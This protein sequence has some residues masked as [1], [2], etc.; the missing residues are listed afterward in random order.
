MKRK[1]LLV[2]TGPAP[3]GALNENVLLS[4][5]PGMVTSNS[6]PSRSAER[7][8]LWNDVELQDRAQFGEATATATSHKERLGQQSWSQVRGLS[9]L[10]PYHCA[11]DAPSLVGD[12]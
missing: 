4:E 3:T 11:T 6:A 9:V 1:G 2:G 10:E 8:T 5:E 12:I 7:D